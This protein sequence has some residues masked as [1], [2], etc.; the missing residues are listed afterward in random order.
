MRRSAARRAANPPLVIGGLARRYL[1]SGLHNSFRTTAYVNSC[2]RQFVSYPKSGRTWVRYVF[3]QLGLAQHLGIH[4]DGFELD[5]A[6]KPPHDF[7]LERRLRRYRRIDRLVFLDRDPRDVMVS[8]YFE[9]TQ[10]LQDRF[11]WEGDISTFLRD[12]YFGAES[13]HRFR[14]VWH[15]VVRRRGF[16][17]VTYEEMHADS[18]GTMAKMIEYYGFEVPVSEIERALAAST[19]EKMRAVEVS[20]EFP[21]P[22]LRVRRE[23]AAL[24]TRSGR[25]GSYS[26]LAADDI[27]Y[28]NDVFGLS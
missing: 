17:E 10:R 23:D 25:I 18:V 27:A 9:V 12:P 3:V 21:E 2:D 16:V 26:E 8:L 19:F 22:W 4:H 24:K 13:L 11:R 20:N 5:N 14:E 15:E 7:S 28:L 1:P 6:R